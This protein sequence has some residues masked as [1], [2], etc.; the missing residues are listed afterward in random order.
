KRLSDGISIL[1]NHTY[2]HC[3]SDLW[4]AFPGQGGSAI[5]PHNRRAERGNCNGG[6]Q[7]H[8]FNLS[9]V[10]QTP[11]FQGKLLRVI[12]SN[13]QFSPILKLKSSQFFT[14]T[15]GV[16]TALS[17]TGAQ[18]PDLINPDPYPSNQSVDGWINASAFR[19]TAPGTYSNVGMFNLKGPGVFQFDVALSRTFPIWEKRS[20]QLRGEAFNLPNHL[21]PGLPVSATNSAV[22]GKILNDISGTSGLSS[23]DQRIV[24]V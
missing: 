1:A 2:S 5:T 19:A 14:V 10:M 4:N 9:A 13:W 23:G 20:I 8:V 21:N 11:K 7:R 17:G 6:D 22:F 15:S 24:Q 3:I 12:A 16:D 18:R